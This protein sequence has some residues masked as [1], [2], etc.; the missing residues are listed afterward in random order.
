MSTQLPGSSPYGAVILERFRRP[1]RRG[2]LAAANVRGERANALCGDRV[3]VELAVDPTTDRVRDAGFVGDAC[4]VCVAAAS[5]L[6]DHVVGATLGDAEGVTAEEIVTWLEAPLP[7]SRHA[8]AR[9]PLDAMLAGI[10][11]YRAAARR[12]SSSSRPAGESGEAA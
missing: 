6:A 2:A 10:A 11:E 9:L 7:E 8:C 3:R 12:A 1:R 5:L 4:A